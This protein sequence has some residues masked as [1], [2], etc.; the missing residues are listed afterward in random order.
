MIPLKRP[1]LWLLGFFIC[2][3]LFSSKVFAFITAA[4]LCVVLYR[5]YRYWQVLI[6][7]AFFLL[8]AWRINHSLHNHI[9]EPT[10]VTF[11]GTVL[12]TGYTSGGNQRA[13]VRGT[14]Q[15]TGSRLRITAY[16]RPHQRHVI[17][18][19]E[20]TF[21]GELL[22]LTYP[23]NPVDY[24]QFQH[25]RSQKID[26]VIRPESIK[27]GGVRRSLI[28]IL[29]GFRDK[30]AAVYDEILPPREAAV[31]KSMI[32]GDRMDMDRDLADLYRVMGIFHI[33]SI[34]GLHVT[35]IMLAANRL[36]SLVIL[37]RRAALIVLCI[38][39]LYCLMTGAAVST[40]RA[41]T[42]GGVLAGAKLLYRD[43]DLITSL[44]WACLAL[45]LYEPLY[46][47]NVGFQLSFGA[48][49]G[50]AVLTAPT[51]RFL[52]KLKMP[53]FK[54]FRKNLAVGI[55]AIV[56]TNIVFAYHFYEIPLYSVVGNIIIMPTVGI[57]LVLGLF[58]GLI[59]L[60][61]M[62][63]S[64]FLSGIVY[65]ILRFYEAS[66]I[67]ISSLP[68]A[69]ILTGGGNLIISAL[70]IAVLCS[71]AYAFR[72]FENMKRKLSLFFMCCVLLTLALYL[73]ANPRNLQITELETRG[74][75][76]V[77]RHGSDTLII[78]AAHGGEESLLRYLDKRGKSRAALLLTH[79]PHPD[80]ITRLA[81][82][83]PR[84]HTLYLPAH[85]G[86]VTEFLMNQTLGQIPMENTNIIFL[87]DGDKRVFRC[88]S[89]QVRALILGRFEVEVTG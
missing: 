66:A 7:A 13:V 10:Q 43:Y 9:L 87:N 79:P 60:V 17:L 22:P 2:G 32:L 36:L 58:V 38:M 53:P 21:E 39:I 57:I 82:L 84:I 24:N 41:V 8:G 64:Y 63:L 37:E 89:V 35:I 30:I 15:T 48:V 47:F 69:M 33:L 19:Q 26:A 31:V 16:I 6:F 78:G 71:F 54:G 49:F 1:V 20:V 86:S 67:L 55:S 11:S 56:S 34:S 14:C 3:I 51:E 68:Y 46:L 76:M 72:E 18:G 4:V 23:V 70:G 44:A 40:V 29:R 74:E 28:V 62:P 42:M 50:I 27:T 85:A 77:L 5:L 52:S 65:F 80:D 81:Q 73:N 45:L 88:T 75:Y 59:G 61:I 12:D 83:M 25:L